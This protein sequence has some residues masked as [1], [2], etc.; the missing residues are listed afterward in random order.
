MLFTGTKHHRQ[1]FITM[2]TAT[3]MII[4]NRA[5][6]EGTIVIVVMTS[7]LRN[8]CDVERRQVR[9]TMTTRVDDDDATARDIR[10]Q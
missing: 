10:R 1:G 5:A 6:A 9:V 7:I 8:A 4:M 2:A 3:S